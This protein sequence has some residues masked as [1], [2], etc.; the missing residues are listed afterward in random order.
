MAVIAT[1]SAPTFIE[2]QQ[3]LRYKQSAS[4]IANSLKTAR[5][6]SISLN[7]QHGLKFVTANRSY[8]FCRYSSNNQWVYYGT[9]EV[10]ANRVV[11]DLNGT[12]ASAVAP[13]PN[14]RFN[15]N[16]SSFDNYSV[17]IK[18]TN[19]TSKYTVSVD[20]SG[21]IKMTKK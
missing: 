12:A 17:R 4:E 7:K 14:I 18:D 2:W 6:K 21:R 8:Q 13:A 11:L 9:T 15:Y 3:N 1:F 20:R 16:G 5:S 19:N 10:L